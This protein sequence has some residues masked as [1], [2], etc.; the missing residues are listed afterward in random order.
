MSFIVRK[1]KENDEFEIEKIGT[2][3]YSSDYYEGIESFFSKIYGYKDGCFVCEIE[4]KICGYI[5]SFPYLL[6]KPYPINQIYNT[7]EDH[8]CYYIHDLCV[9]KN[10]RKLGVAKALVEKVISID[11]DPKVLTAVQD[12]E[13]FWVKFGFDIKKEINYCGKKAFYMIKDK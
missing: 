1:I 12:S 5:I 7:P 11:Y 9:D 3:N 10:Y 13:K 6:N 2:N 8:N 4:D